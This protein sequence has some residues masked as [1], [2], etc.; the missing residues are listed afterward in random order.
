M[1]ASKPKSRRTWFTSPSVPN[2]CRQS[3]AMATELPSI[4]GR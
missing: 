3:R 1:V 4:D 2:I